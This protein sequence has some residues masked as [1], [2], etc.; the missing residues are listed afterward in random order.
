MGSLLDALA[1]F[2]AVPLG[3]MTW[4][5]SS[6]SKRMVAFEI[7]PHIHGTLRVLLLWVSAAI[8]SSH[9]MRAFLAGATG[10]LV[11]YALSD[12]SFPVDLWCK[13]ALCCPSLSSHGPT[14]SCMIAM[15]VRLAVWYWAAPAT[16]C[17]TPNDANALRRSASAFAGVAMPCTKRR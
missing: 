1:T 15:P 5:L 14:Y 8:H 3:T 9:M 11:F 7:L 17:S 6:P 10:S 16:E 2:L 12:L 4:V 13:S